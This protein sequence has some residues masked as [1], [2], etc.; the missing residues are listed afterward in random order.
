MHDQNLDH[1]R[2]QAKQF[3]ATL[4]PLAEANIAAYTQAIEQLYLQ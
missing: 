1:Y 2:A 3:L 4:D